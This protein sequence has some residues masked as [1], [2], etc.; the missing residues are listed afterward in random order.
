MS[1]HAA[2][3]VEEPVN[4][5]PPSVPDV[6]HADLATP[7]WVAAELPP[8]YGEVAQKIAALR[9]EALKYEGVAQVLWRTGDPLVFAVRD[10]FEA[11]KYRV[12]LS[13][14]DSPRGVIVELEGDRRL[15]VVVAGSPGAIERQSPSVTELLRLLQEEAREGDRLVLAVNAFHDQ[16]LDARRDGP[17]AADAL[18]LIQRLG[19]NVIPT[20][21]LF[22]MWKYAFTDP[23]AAR[24][25]LVRLHRQDGGIFK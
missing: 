3:P 6:P 13:G 21:T 11:L 4:V 15:L 19:A 24:Q 17:V 1:P 8:A 7:P 9:I 23:D 25:S 2:T 20:V 16:P 18:K 5:A 22:G 12:S 10:L 14:G